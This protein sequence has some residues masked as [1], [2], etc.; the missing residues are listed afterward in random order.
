VLPFWP[1]FR[2]ENE[3]DRD[4]ASSARLLG[5]VVW[6][7]GIST[8]AGIGWDGYEDHHQILHHNDMPRSPLPQ[9][10]SLLRI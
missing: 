4:R 8:H 5:R 6:G 9:R 7:L 3:G 2:E 10:F 1:G